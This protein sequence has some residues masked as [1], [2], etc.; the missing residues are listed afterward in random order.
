MVEV[1][2][3]LSDCSRLSDGFAGFDDE[4]AWRLGGVVFTQKADRFAVVRKAERDDYEFSGLWALPGGMVRPMEG[5]AS[6]AA[7]L[8]ST[9]SRLTAEAGLSSEGL[10]LRTDLGPI[11][12]SY[13]VKGKRRFTLVASLSTISSDD[14]ELRPA[15]GSVCEADWADI[16]WGADVFAPANRILLAHQLWPVMDAACRQQ[17]RPSVESA[18]VDCTQWAEAIGLGAPAAPWAFRPEV[19]TWIASWPSRIKSS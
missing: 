7:M 3:C 6:S 17:W 1:R 19:A 16:K 5:E 8:R 15:D 12:T 18:L 9:A 4:A 10:R 13:T 2:A 11:A 14:A